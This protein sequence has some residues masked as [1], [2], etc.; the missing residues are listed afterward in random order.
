M[1]EKTVTGAYLPQTKPGEAEDPDRTPYTYDVAYTV[2][3]D[4]SITASGEVRRGAKSWPY[5]I[6]TIVANDRLD[7]E[8]MVRRS[9]TSFIDE[10][11]KG[12]RAE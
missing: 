3:V 10:S 5:S 4:G 8:Y 6:R 11:D 9:A 1:D 7:P 12:W 2:Q